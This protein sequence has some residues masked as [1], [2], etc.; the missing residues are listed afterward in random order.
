MTNKDDKGTPV[1]ADPVARGMALVPDDPWQKLRRFTNARI[2]LGRAGN[3]LPTREVLQFALA[4][5]MARDAVHW[6][7]DWE[8]LRTPMQQERFTVLD[9]HSCA[10]DRQSYL[11]RPDLG[12]RLDDTSRSRLAAAANEGSDLV[13]VL[14]DGLSALAV[15]K[16]ALPLLRA[17]HPLLPPAWRLGPVVLASQA[18]VALGDEIGQCLKAKMVA[19]LIGERP[20]LSSPDSLGAYLTLRPQVGKMDSERNCVSNIRPE[21]LTCGDAARRIA[22]LLMQAMRLGQTGIGLKDESGSVHALDNT[23]TPPPRLG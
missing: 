10:S 2:A 12:R 3:S 11:L 6:E 14:A 18:R 8:A 21:G 16:H 17:L 13:I 7:I 23:D 1:P 9:A 19:V 4:H 15:Q 20:G 5:A 22:W